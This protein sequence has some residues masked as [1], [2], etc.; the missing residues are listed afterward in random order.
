VTISHTTKKGRDDATRP[1]AGAMGL[2]EVTAVPEEGQQERNA[3]VLCSVVPRELASK[4]LAALG[5]VLPMPAMGLDHLKRIRK[6]GNGAEQQLQIIIGTLPAVKS[7]PKG[8]LDGLY[9]A[10]RLQPVERLVPAT[11]AQTREECERLSELWPMTLK[12]IAVLEAQRAALLLQ[13]GEAEAMEEL[14]SLALEDAR[15]A[16]AHLQVCGGAAVGAVIVDPTSQKLVSSASAERERLL[17]GEWPAERGGATSAANHPLL[18]PIMLCISGVAHL[19]RNAECPRSKQDQYLCTG[20]DVYTTRE[21]CIMCAMALVHSRIRR[22]M[23]GVEAPFGGLG[24]AAALHT[25]PL[26]HHYRVFKGLRREECELT[27]S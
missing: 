15:R 25:L 13:P 1:R 5:G 7:L 24:S 2:V 16:R 9:D 23:Y 12:K 14:M 27:L 3:T 18:H 6:T 17:Q 11:E 26:N 22:V 19:Q 8:V 20:F 10:H 21:P 4:A